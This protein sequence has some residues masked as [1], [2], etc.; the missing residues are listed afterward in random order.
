MRRADWTPLVL[1][2]AS[3][4][5]TVVAAVLLTTPWLRAPWGSEPG[6][7]QERRHLADALQVWVGDVAPDVRG[8]LAPVWGEEEPDRAHD[9][10]LNEQLGLTGARALAWYHLLLFNRSEAPQRVSLADGALLIRPAGGASRVALRN[11]A[12]LVARGEARV[13]PSLAA[14]LTARGALSESVEV[15]AG[16]MADLLVA[17]DGRVPLAEAFGVATS[18]GSVFTRRPMTRRELDE[19]VEDPAGPRLEDL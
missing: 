17:F 15:P 5:V 18:T 9:A 1:I 2:T 14:V 11:L 7:A 16:W 4:S 13:A 3:I 19:L 6:P 8:L 12:G 10:R